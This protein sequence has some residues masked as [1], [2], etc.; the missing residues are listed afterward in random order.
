MCSQKTGR[1]SVCLFLAKVR[2]CKTVICGQKAAR[3]AFGIARRM[4]SS[5]HYS[6]L[7]FPN[8]LACSK[9]FKEKQKTLVL[10][11]AAFAIH[12]S[13]KRQSGQ[14]SFWDCLCVRLTSNGISQV[15]WLN[16][17]SSEW[18]TLSGFDMVHYGLPSR[19]SA[20]FLNC[21]KS[22]GDLFEFPP[23]HH[24]RHT[25]TRTLNRNRFPKNPA[26]FLHTIVYCVIHS[27]YSKQFKVK[28]IHNF[29]LLEEFKKS[30]LF[31]VTNNFSC[32]IFVC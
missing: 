16:F 31:L 24:H 5:E 9:N 29:N 20:N 28:L 22:S 12:V 17:D 27:V 19:V 3:A 10:F 11:G 25:R 7:N 2:H 8:L 32:F 26:G 30:L 18:P 14:I 1:S 13:C 21:H 6:D 4:I 15:N 23:F